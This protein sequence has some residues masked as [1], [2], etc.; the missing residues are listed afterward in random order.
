MK[1]NNTI[2]RLQEEFKDSGVRF[3]SITVDPEND[4]RKSCRSTRSTSAPTPSA[5]CS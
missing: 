2:A 3:V 5:G 4:S 1:M